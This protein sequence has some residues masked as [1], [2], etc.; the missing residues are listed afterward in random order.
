[1]TTLQQPLQRNTESY[2]RRLFLVT[3]IQELEDLYPNKSDSELYQMAKTEW[4]KKVTRGG[5]N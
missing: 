1:M 5:N 3:K 2:Q 4:N